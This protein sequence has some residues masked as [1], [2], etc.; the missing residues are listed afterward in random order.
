MQALGCVLISQVGGLISRV[1]ALPWACGPD[2]PKTAAAADGIWATAGS[3]QKRGREIG[4]NNM[5]MKRKSRP[6]AGILP[7]L[8]QNPW[9]A[10]R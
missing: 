1:I 5:V 4:L 8:Q 6:L 2:R 3:N 10:N 7:F 9:A